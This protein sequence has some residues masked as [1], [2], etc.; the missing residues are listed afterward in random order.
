MN[1]NNTIHTQTA[2]NL[3]RQLHRWIDEIPLYR[4][5]EIYAVF[6]GLFGK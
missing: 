6:K 3:R 1:T 4:I 2:D 5:G